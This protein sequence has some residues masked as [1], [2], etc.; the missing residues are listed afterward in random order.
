MSEHGE[1][2]GPSIGDVKRKGQ[3]IKIPGQLI[4]V[5]D[6]AKLVRRIFRLYLEGNSI[7]KIAETLTK[8]GIRT[9][10]GNTVWHATVISKMLM[11]EK[12]MGDA[13]LQKTIPWISWRKK[14]RSIKELCHSI[15]SKEIM[16]R[17]SPGTVLSGTGGAGPQGNVL[18]SSQ[19]EGSHHPGKIQLQVCA[20]R[21]HVLKECGQ[22]YR[23]QVWVN[24]G[25]K[26]GVAL[27]Q[28]LEERNQK[29]KHSPSL[30]EKS[31]S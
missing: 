6:E 30:E 1:S 8:E 21:H 23:R 2:A 13:L 4:I 15:T 25:T 18:P 20:S 14:E 26:A 31:A 27:L 11:N 7:N 3:R 12:Y 19:Q 10:T 5:P 28:P 9:V 22:P 16:K 29:C 17:L 24:G